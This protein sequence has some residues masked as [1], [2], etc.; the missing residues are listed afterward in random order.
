MHAALPPSCERPILEQFRRAEAMALYAVRA[1]QAHAPAHALEFL[2]RHEQEE[3]EHLEIFETL[4]ATRAH[5]RETLP[6]VPEQWPALAVHLFGYEAL[7]LEFARLL[8]EIRPDLGHILAD[9]EQ[10]VAFFEREVRRVIEAGDPSAT[11]ARD[12]GLRWWRRLPPTLDRYLR[13]EEL[14]PFRADVRARILGAIELKLSSSGLLTG[15]R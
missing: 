12:Y 13:G 7:G 4:T 8:A 14:D 6:S 10:H 15:R 3:R 11:A 2:K 1:A 5:G 9:E